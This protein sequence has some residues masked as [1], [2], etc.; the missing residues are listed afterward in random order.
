MKTF[1]QMIIVLFIINISFAQTN[2]YVSTAG[3]DANDGSQVS[4]WATI[5][6]AVNNVSNPSVDLIVINISTG[7]YDLSNDQIDIDRNFVNLTLVG[8]GRDNT[9]IQSSADTSLSS[10]R[11]IKIYS[12]NNVLLKNLT[13]RYGRISFP[14]V[15]GAGIL[16][17]LGTLMIDYC[18]VT[19]NSTG[20]NTGGG[21]GGITNYDGNL[22]IS[23][24]TISYNTTSDS[25]I[26]AG[27]NSRNGTLNIYNSTICYNSAYAGGGIAVLSNGANAIF[28][29]ENSTVYGNTAGL[30]FGG[31]RISVF[32]EQPSI[33]DI[34]TNINNCTIF[35]NSADDFYGGIGLTS[36]SS[37][38]I[39]NS[40]VAGNTSGVTANDLTGTLLIPIEITSGGYNIFQSVHNLTINGEQNNGIGIDPGL[41]ALADN[42]SNNHT[43]TCAIPDSSFA[44]D[45]IPAV[46]SNGSPLFDQRGFQRIGDY[47]IGAFELSE[48]SDVTLSDESL[49]KIF[50][51]NQ[52]YP[53]PFNPITTVQYSIPQRSN[54]TLKV[55]DVLGNEIAELVNEE[56][57]MGVYSVSF[58]AS[59]LASGIYLYKIQAGS[60]VET[61]KMILLK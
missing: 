24:S 38:N 11:V 4:P 41:L 30:Y 25:S 27:I 7:V 19:E 31:I 58:D 5:E 43:Q 8:D 35:N 46:S 59:N 12:G 49:P 55:Y 57:G 50:N 6:Y 20:I 53:N 48:I 45:Q 40:I 39:K 56:K 36:P 60:F 37:F 44:K 3:S 29:M 54:V 32:G 61:K 17:V 42:N 28:N 13:V 1:F 52:N 16:N 47:D 51:L 26:G 18:K 9:F 10:S 21:G 34:V 22:T 33:Y 15:Y 23:N 14:E 2:Y